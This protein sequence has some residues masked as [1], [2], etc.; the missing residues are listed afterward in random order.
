MTV[1]ELMT[2]AFQLSGEPSDLCPFVT[3]GDPVTFD[4]GFTQSSTL[5]LLGW[6]NTAIARIANWEYPDGTMLRFRNLRRSLVFKTKAA[7]SQAVVIGGTDTV[8]IMGF[9]GLNRAGQ[10]DGWIV[11]VTAGT[12][13]G[14]RRLVIATTGVGA[15]NSVLQVA[16]DWAVVPDSSSTVSLY[17]RF[18][19]FVPVP[20][21]GTVDDYHLPGDSVNLIGDV[22]MVR[23]IV[24]MQDLD[25]A[26]QTELFTATMLTPGIPSMFM[27]SGSRLVF[28]VPFSGKRSYEAVYYGH[29]VP[30]VAVT[31]P[32]PM[33]LPFHE[34]VMDWMVHSLQ[35]RAQDFNGAYA[36]K[37]DLQ[38]LM[39]TLRNSGELDLDNVN[40]GFVLYS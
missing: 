32:L 2:R 13:I 6:L 7:L 31:D 12:G 22:T 29:P 38:E 4:T 33:S 18:F 15:N 27:A 11:D 5:A 21:T 24:S 28:D 36:T 8:E 17:K 3:P 30:I 35:M 10:F 16:V 19:E 23:D 40:S 26:G 14:Q 9:S 34:A 39:Q 20:V 1:Q 37:R 25:K